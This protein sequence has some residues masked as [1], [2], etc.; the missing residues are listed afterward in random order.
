MGVCVTL[1]EN[2]EQNLMIVV[3]QPIPHFSFVKV[4]SVYGEGNGTPVQYSCLENPMDG[5]ALVGCSPWGH[6]R[7]GHN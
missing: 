5:G 6:K 4:S 7:I 3:S 1:S 2:I